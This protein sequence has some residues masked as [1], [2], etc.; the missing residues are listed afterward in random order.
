MVSAHTPAPWVADGVWVYDANGLTVANCGD[1][2][3][4]HLQRQETARLIA[5]APELLEALEAA[6]WTGE[7]RPFANEDQAFWEAWLPRARAAVAKARGEAVP[8]G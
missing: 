8:H 1:M 2:N 7:R 5:A 6:V 4:R 3:R